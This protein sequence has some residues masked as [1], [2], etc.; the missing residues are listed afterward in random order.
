MV[1][2][3][4][5]HL[6][7]TFHNEQTPMAAAIATL[8]VYMHKNV[9]N[10][11]NFIGNQLIQGLSNL[12]LTFGVKACIKKYPALFHIIF[13]NERIETAFHRALQSR[14]ILFHPFDPQMV[15]FCH[16][17]ADICYTLQAVEEVLKILSKKFPTEFGLSDTSLSQASLDFR[18]LHEFGGLMNYNLP[19]EQIPINWFQNDR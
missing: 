8:D 6:V 10:K 16:S 15:N 4:K 2:R 5:T 17:E 7:G 9:I 1:A 11:L 19:I 14:G 13:D 3:E 18:T 12:F